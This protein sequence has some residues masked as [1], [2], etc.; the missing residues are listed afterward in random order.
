LIARV[1]PAALLLLALAATP[2]TAQDRA[3]VQD[4]G[5]VKVPNAISLPWAFS[6]A[7]AHGFD[8][9]PR[10]ESPAVGAGWTG[11][12]FGGL[13]HRRLRPRSEITLDGRGSGY[14]LRDPALGDRVTYSASG[15]GSFD[16]DPRLHA[17][18]AESWQNNYADEATALALQ[19]VLLRT[20]L[21]R[22]NFADGT[23][24]YRVAERTTLT[25]EARHETVGFHPAGTLFGYTRL[26]GTLGATRRLTAHD[27][28]SV[29][30]AFQQ[31]SARGRQGR[32]VAAGGGWER[33]FGA[34]VSARLTAGLQRFDT[35]ATGARRTQPYATALVE[36]RY[37]HRLFT[38]DYSHTLTPG[39]EDGRDRILDLVSLAGVDNFGPRLAVFAS[40]SGGRRRDLDPTGLRTLMLRTSAGLSVRIA[41]RLEA[42]LTHTYERNRDREPLVVRTRQRADVSLGYRREW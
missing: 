24:A 35:L 3:V 22:S 39:Y 26:T 16:L 4:P 1:G 7:Y 27:A 42:R 19:G 17:T 10:F 15:T 13:T 38:A 33:G 18:L 31:R 23:L 21:A 41:R 34:R 9:N 12:V 5:L 14:V 36:G 2:A 28:V 37:R 29:T 11:R 20:I 40:V 25:A 32:G 6:L 30:A 8:D